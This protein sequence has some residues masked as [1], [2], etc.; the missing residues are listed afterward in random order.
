MDSTTSLSK[1]TASL[2]ESCI[3]CPSAEV[4]PEACSE[5]CEKAQL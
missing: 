1:S 3:D 4:E 5:A 2:A